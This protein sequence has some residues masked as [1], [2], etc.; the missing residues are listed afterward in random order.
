MGVPCVKTT[1]ESTA[2]D[3]DFIRQAPRPF[4]TGEFLDENIKGYGGGAG[5]LLPDIIAIPDVDRLPF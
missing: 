4:E 5:L 3:V 2:S 1:I